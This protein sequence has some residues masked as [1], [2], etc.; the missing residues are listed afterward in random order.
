M[1]AGMVKLY[2]VVFVT[3][4]IWRSNHMSKTGVPEERVLG[5][6]FRIVTSILNLNIRKPEDYAM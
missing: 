4:S 3:I 1:M 2:G 6:G 5:M